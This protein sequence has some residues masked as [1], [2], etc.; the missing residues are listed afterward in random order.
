V[1]EPGALLPRAREIAAEIIDRTGAVSVALARALVWRMLGAR[2]PY[3]AHRLESLAIF[4]MGQSADAEE[5]VA[6]FLEKRAPRFPLKV[7]R[8]MPPFYPWWDGAES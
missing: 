2:D 3:E 6:S 4:Y 1:L 8:D 5:G 7:S